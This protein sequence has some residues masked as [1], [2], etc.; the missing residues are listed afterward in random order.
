MK[1]IK[2][3]AIVKTMGE[4]TERFEVNRENLSFS[5]L[6]FFFLF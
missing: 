6:D 1:D 3:T 5:R 4:G 2:R